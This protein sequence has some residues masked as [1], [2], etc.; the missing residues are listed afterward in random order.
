ME[1]SLLKPIR[2][3]AAGLAVALLAG[4]SLA[5]TP[6]AGPPASAPSAAPSASP[7]AAS[8]PAA[9]GSGALPGEAGDT[10]VRGYLRLGEAAFQAG[11]FPEAEEW[12][13]KAFALRP[14]YDVASNLAAAE[15]AQSKH[16]EAAAHFALALRT[17]PATADPEKKRPLEQRF[18]ESRAKVGAIRVTVNVEGAEIL[19]AG[20]VVAKSPAL[21]AVF[22]E[23]GT[24]ELEA[25][26]GTRRARQSVTIAAG[27]EQ[28]VELVLEPADGQKGGGELPVWPV[29][30]GAGLTV[31]AVAI[32]VVMHVVAAGQLSDAD[33]RRDELQSTLLQGGGRCPAAPG[34]SD[35]ESLYS[36]KDTSANAGTGLLVAGGV[37][38]AATLVYLA[39][40]LTTDSGAAEAA[41]ASAGVQLL[42]TVLPGLQGIALRARY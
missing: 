2:P 28:D 11:R 29:G 36:D 10:E 42:P 17:F 38:G 12:F 8:A 23:P 25:R 22:V 37:L 19:V 40:W 24:V 30:V 35:L 16:R 20:Q 31:A 3:L 27:G 14:G 26:I 32:G 5:A 13:E 1:M 9:S 39:A 34:C 18:G 33:T 15:Q 7:A 41:G 4:S 6:P 21:D